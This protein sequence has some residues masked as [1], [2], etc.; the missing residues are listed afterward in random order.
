MEKQCDYCEKW[1]IC[2]ETYLGLGWYKPLCKKC[3]DSLEHSYDYQRTID[4]YRSHKTYIDHKK[5]SVH[6]QTRQ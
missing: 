1:D 3:N 5:L 4:I 6:S 2:I